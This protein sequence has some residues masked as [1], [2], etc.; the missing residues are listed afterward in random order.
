VENF[1]QEFSSA[2]LGSWA[3]LAELR[4]QQK[5]TSDEKEWQLIRRGRYIEFN[6]LYAR[7]IKFGL[8]GGRMESIMV[9]APPSVKWKY[10]VVPEKGSEEERLIEVLRNPYEWV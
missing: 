6:L 3:P 5:Y 8:N 1:V 9:S 10:N 2:I 4:N 7:G